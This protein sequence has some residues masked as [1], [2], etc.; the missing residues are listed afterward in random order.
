MP[1]RYAH[2]WMLNGRIPE[3]CLDLARWLR[4]YQT[5]S[6]QIARTE[7]MNGNLVIVTRFRGHAERAGAF[8][9]PPML[10]ESVVYGEAHA[11]AFRGIPGS[12]RERVDVRSYPTW[13]AAEC[14]HQ[15]L[16]ARYRAL[17]DRAEHFTAAAIARSASRAPGHGAI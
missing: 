13:Q 11:G 7:L 9:P 16:V 15:E 2:L 14:G 1:M 3:P 5:A 12:V 4:W 17:L 8:D 10:F 6:T